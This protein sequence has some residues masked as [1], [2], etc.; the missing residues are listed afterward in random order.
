MGARNTESGRLRDR[1]PE[2]LRTLREQVPG[3]G[4]TYQWLRAICPPTPTYVPAG[5]AGGG[6]RGHPLPMAAHFEGSD[7]EERGPCQGSASRSGELGS[8][9]YLLSQDSGS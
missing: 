3:G 9:G 2:A 4:D 7:G 1:E 8:G 5:G 6:V